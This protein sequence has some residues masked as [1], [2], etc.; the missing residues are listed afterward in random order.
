MA[1]ESLDN[2][3]DDNIK[4]CEAIGEATKNLTARARSDAGRSSTAVQD[5]VQVLPEVREQQ[6]S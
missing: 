1:R 3:K 5:G 2:T 6:S 4:H